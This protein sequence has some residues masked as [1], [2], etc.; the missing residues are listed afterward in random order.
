MGDHRQGEH[1]PIQTSAVIVLGAAKGPSLPPPSPPTPYATPAD[2]LCEPIDSFQLAEP[3][4][5]D[6]SMHEQ[7]LRGG[8]H[9]LSTEAHALDNLSRLYETDIVARNGFDQAVEVITSQAAAGGKL[10]IIGVGKSGHIGK[11]LVATFQSLSIRSVFL[12]PT[13]ALH[14]DLG[15]VSPNDVLMF[16][17]YSGSTKELMLLLPHLEESLPTILLTSHTRGDTCEFIKQRPSTI[18]LPAPVHEPEKTSFGVSAPTTSTTAALAL[19]DALAITA[20]SELHPNP[21]RVFAKNHPGGAIGAAARIQPQTL[22]H[23]CVPWDDIPSADISVE[24]SGVDLLRA[25]YDS[26]CGWV[27]ISDDLIAS[28]STIRAS[29]NEGCIR[30]VLVSRPQMLDM[31]CETTIRTARHILQDRLNA[32]LD[33]DLPCQLGSVIAVKKKGSIIGLLEVGSIL[34]PEEGEN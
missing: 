34:E 18:L 29:I 13:E 6:N 12:H 27:K 9:V 4:C 7:R 17:T 5:N 2:S 11:K 30:N 19:G 20:S 10:V 15:I 24:S 3:T 16:I 32:S 21:A 28:P 22:E 25:G 26:P 33:D 14:G 31:S 1:R 23:I 8:I